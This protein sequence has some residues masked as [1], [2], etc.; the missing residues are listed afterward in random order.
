MS[1]PQKLSELSGITGKYIDFSKIKLF[2]QRDNIDV[3]RKKTCKENYLNSISLWA[4]NSKYLNIDFTNNIIF[5]W[6]LRLT[7]TLI[8]FCHYIDNGFML[9]SK[10][11]NLPNIISNLYTSYPQQIPI[12]F[13]SNHHTTRYLDLSLSLNHFTIRYHYS[14]LPDLPETTP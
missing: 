10:K 9:T 8:I 6:V 14:P 1:W 13:T 2:C 3:S 5:F 7:D 4:L 11:A 12:T